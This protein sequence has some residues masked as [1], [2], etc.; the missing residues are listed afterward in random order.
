MV[1]N[2]SN[3]EQRVPPP[4]HALILMEISFYFLGFF[5]L[6]SFFLFAFF[7]VPG[8][9][10]ISEWERGVPMDSFSALY[11]IINASNNSSSRPI[12]LLKL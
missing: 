7:L 4:D 6:L 1:K 8:F 3:V 10:D 12:A 9:Y 11:D 5:S 2:T